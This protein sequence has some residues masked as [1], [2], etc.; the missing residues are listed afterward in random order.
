VISYNIGSGGVMGDTIVYHT[1]LHTSSIDL[2]LPFAQ[3]ELKFNRKSDVLEICSLVMEPDSIGGAKGI[4]ISEEYLL[5][6]R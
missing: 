3:V 1:T 6:L 2:D 4:K 5:M